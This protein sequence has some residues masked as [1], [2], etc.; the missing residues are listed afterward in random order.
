[1]RDTK[2][3]EQWIGK[4]L[5]ISIIVA[6]MMI[7]VGGLSYLYHTGHQEFDHGLIFQSHTT[8]FSTLSGVWM[9]LT[10][11]LG[12]IQAGLLLIILGQIVRV[13]LTGF[14]FLLQRDVFFVLSTAIILLIMVLGFCH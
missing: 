2:A 7:S 8:E 10:T 11:P 13:A 14:I 6:L 1:M 5:L 12:L 3:L 4:I 9:H